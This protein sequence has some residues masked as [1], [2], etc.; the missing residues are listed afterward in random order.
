MKKKKE[1]SI[2]EWWAN[3]RNCNKHVMRV[4][5]GEE[6]KEQKKYWIND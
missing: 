3:H 1:E 6:R 4:S 5:E 2:Q